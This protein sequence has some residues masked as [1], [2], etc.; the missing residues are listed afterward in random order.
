[1]PH[2]KALYMI[3]I[4]YIIIIIYMIKIFALYFML[5]IASQPAGPNW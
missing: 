2:I 4:L 5:D 3:I 1:M